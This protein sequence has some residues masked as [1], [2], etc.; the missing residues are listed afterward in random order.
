MIDKTNNTHEN[1]LCYGSPIINVIEVN[2][3]GV[4]CQSGNESMYEKD[5]GDGGFVEED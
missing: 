2:V 1:R 3:Q 4:L 5:L